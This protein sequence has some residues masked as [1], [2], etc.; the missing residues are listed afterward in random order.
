MEMTYDGA[1]VMPK[2]FAIVAEDEMEYVDGGLSIPNWLVGGAINLAISAVLTMV[3][4][5]LAKGAANNLAWVIKKIGKEVVESEI[6]KRVERAAG[7][8]AASFVVGIIGPALT[9]FGALFDPGQAIAGWLDGRDSNPGNGY[10]N[11]G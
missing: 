6:K 1:L 5:G 8:M 2:N 7:L 9:L 10:L 11:I 4:A 3:G